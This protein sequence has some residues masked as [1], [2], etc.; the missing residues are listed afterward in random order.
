MSARE[1]NAGSDI[2][3]FINSNNY[4]GGPILVVLYYQT[5]GI[6]NVATIVDEYQRIQKFYTPQVN[7]NNIVFARILA[8]VVSA[9]PNYRVIY[10]NEFGI[11]Y[12]GQSF[13]SHM[14][15][16]NDALLSGLS[17]AGEDFQTPF[18]T[19]IDQ[20]LGRQMKDRPML[21]S[22]CQPFLTTGASGGATSVIYSTVTVTQDPV[23]VTVTADAEQTSIADMK[24]RRRGEPIRRG[25]PPGFMRRFR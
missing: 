7:A 10:D 17:P 16:Y 14:D 6:S 22:Q 5:P 21:Y 25:P 9:N 23:T 11:Y 15:A 4:P 1:F 12:N 19:T 20:V 8:G 3:N 13:F 18:K 24:L 2:M